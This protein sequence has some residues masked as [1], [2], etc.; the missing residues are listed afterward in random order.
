MTNVV[1]LEKRGAIAVITIDN[2]P[3][4]ALGQAVRQGLLQ[5]LGAALADG[6]VAAVVLIGR[7]RTFSG[8]ADITEFGKPPRAPHLHE[9][10]E[11]CDRSDK[12][13][14]AALHGTVM[15]GGLELVLGC[16]HRVAAPGARLG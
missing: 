1:D 13:L 15:G 7:G 9:V 14:V 10:I 4:N 2:P 16:S 3:V 8:G 5:T 12:P 11:A 6:A